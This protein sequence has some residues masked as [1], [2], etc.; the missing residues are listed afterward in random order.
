MF[1]FYNS[2]DILNLIDLIDTIKIEKTVKMIVF[3]KIKDNP[4]IVSNLLD[5]NTFTINSFCSVLLNSFGYRNDDMILK[6]MFMGFMYDNYQDKFYDF[7]NKIGEIQQT[8]DVNDQI[9]NEQIIKE[10]IYIFIS[11]LLV[12]MFTSVVNVYLPKV[13]Q[14]ENINFNSIIL[15]DITIVTKFYNYIKDIN[16]K[17]KDVF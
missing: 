17:Y 14:V 8:K 15:Q 3:D 16:D 1:L 11:K 4:L 12:D 2:S 5:N 6:Y 10:E 13:T 9:V 7:K